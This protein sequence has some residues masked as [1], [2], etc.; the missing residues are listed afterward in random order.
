LF[1]QLGGVAALAVVLAI[2]RAGI[3]VGGASTAAPAA[4]ATALTIVYQTKILTDGGFT[5]FWP[6]DSRPT[7][8]T[9]HE[10]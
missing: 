8:C 7:H 9:T 5:L 10:A 6:D 3:H 1:E 2:A 4:P